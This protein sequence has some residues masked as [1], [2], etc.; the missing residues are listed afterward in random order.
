MFY[1]FKSPSQ[2]PSYFH[3][4]P[5][6]KNIFSMQLALISRQFSYIAAC[7]YYMHIDK[8]TFLI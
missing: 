3:P 6:P 7:V 5:A 1:V 2:F 8:D 4:L